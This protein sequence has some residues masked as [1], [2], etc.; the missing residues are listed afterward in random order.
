MVFFIFTDS[1]E[2]AKEKLSMAENQS[3]LNT[4]TEEK[5]SRHKRAKKGGDFYS[6]PPPST[7]GS[8]EEEDVYNSISNIRDYPKPPKQ[9]K[10]ENTPV[11]TTRVEST[12]SYDTP[13]TSKKNWKPPMHT[14]QGKMLLII[15]NDIILKH[16]ATCLKII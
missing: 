12:G 2:R 7:S 16:F 10:E 9:R 3:D 8:S 4:D 1:F 6:C 5:M 15:Y 14:Q 11:M 13:S